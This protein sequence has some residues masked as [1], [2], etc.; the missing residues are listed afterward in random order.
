MTDSY[1]LLIL[2]LKCVLNVVV[3][4]VYCMCLWLSEIFGT[5]GSLLLKQRCTVSPYCSHLTTI[6]LHYLIHYYALSGLHLQQVI[7]KFLDDL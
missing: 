1:S 5:P 6:I 7:Y 4:C 2:L 3:L